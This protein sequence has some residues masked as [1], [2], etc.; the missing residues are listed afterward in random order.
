MKKGVLNDLPCRVG[1]GHLPPETVQTSSGLQVHPGYGFLSENTH[2]AAQLT[3]AGVTF[4]GPNSRAISDMGDK[5]RS[6]QIAGQAGVNLIP[7]FD[8]VV[9]VGGKLN[10]FNLWPRTRRTARGRRGRSASR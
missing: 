7:G 10:L 8:G 5:I 4:I 1:G 9:Q 2:F 3:D 6:K